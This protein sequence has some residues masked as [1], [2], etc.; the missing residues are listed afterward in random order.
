[1]KTAGEMF[2]DAI[3]HWKDAKGVGTA[4]I[5]SILNDKLMVLGTLQRVY[6]RSPTI[7]TVIITTTFNERRNIIEFLTNQENEEENNQEFKQLIN[8]G[9][10]KV[11]TDDYIKNNHFNNHPRLVILYKPETICSEIYQ[12]I[13]L[14]K[15]KLI[16]INR[17]LQNVD[18]MTLIYKLAPILDDFKQNEVE[19]LKLSTPVEECRIAIDIPIDSE[20]YKLLQYYNEYITTSISIFGSFKIMKEANSGN[21][22]L[23]ISSTQICYKIAT[24][25]GW[26][27]HL[28]M[29]IDFN[30]EIDNLYNPA[31]LKER[32]FQTYEIIRNRSKLLSDYEGKLQSIIDIVS[33]H[34]KEKILIINK[35]GEFASKVTDYI[36]DHFSTLTCMNYH[37]KVDSV[38]TIDANGNPVYYKSG[39]RKGQRKMMASQAQKSLAVELFNKGNINI[40]ST[41]NS[42]DKSL[43]CDLDVIII[44]SPTC[45]DISSYIY[46]LSNLYFRNNKILLYSLYCRNTLEEKLLESK[47]KMVNHSVKNSNEDESFSDFLIVD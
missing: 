5:P 14:C 37:D 28:D 26:N 40:L 33:T 15:F 34:N 1:M 23:N 9:H 45:E 8:D 2:I 21:Q 31:N 17:L 41:N 20:D 39:A 42:P 32:A 44:T 35:R 30:V 4:L 7:Y 47:E 13:S 10:I 16:V 12:Y 18:D 19:Q 46:R 11:F 3:E 29:N 38:P 6:T 27:D 24:E 25:N 43:S 36:N 22:T